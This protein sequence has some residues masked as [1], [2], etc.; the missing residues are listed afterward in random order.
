MEQKWLAKYNYLKNK[1]CRN[2][3]GLYDGELFF[4]YINLFKELYYNLNYQYE[5]TEIEEYRKNQDIE[6]FINVMKHKN[7]NTQYIN[8]QEQ[9]KQELDENNQNIDIAKQ[10]WLNGEI[11]EYDYSQIVEG[12]MY[13]NQ[14]IY[15]SYD[16]QFEEL[17]NQELE[18]KQNI[19]N[20]SGYTR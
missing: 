9:L 7:K 8:L 17:E 12:T 16:E 4:K 15:D 6:D 1:Y 11:N 14:Q 19:K 18:K 13:M 2:Q 20:N 10:M 5:N 3:N